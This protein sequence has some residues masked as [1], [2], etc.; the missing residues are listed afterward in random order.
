MLHLGSLFPFPHPFYYENDWKGD[1]EFLQ[2]PKGKAL[3]FGTQLSNPPKEIWPSQGAIVPLVWWSL[4]SASMDMRREGRGERRYRGL[5]FSPSFFPI[6]TP[7]F[8]G[9]LRTSLLIQHA[10][11]A[12]SVPDSKNRLLGVEQ[13]MR[14]RWPKREALFWYLILWLGGLQQLALHPWS[15]VSAPVKGCTHFYV[16]TFWRTQAMSFVQMYTVVSYCALRGRAHMPFISITTVNIY[17]M[18]GRG[19]PMR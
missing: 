17:G 1:L 5:L 11:C 6:S 10:L 4:L 19:Q 14:E 13:W 9:N 12:R 16:T 8:K 7:F 3:C 2:V 18:W 15:L